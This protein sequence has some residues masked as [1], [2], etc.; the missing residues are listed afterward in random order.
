MSICILHYTGVQ[1][2]RSSFNRTEFCLNIITH[3]D[4]FLKGISSS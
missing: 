3:T 2:Y 4:T 1:L